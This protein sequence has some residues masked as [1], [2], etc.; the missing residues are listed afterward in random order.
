M[1][2]LEHIGIAVDD[3]ET[4]RSRFAELLGTRPYKTETVAD[5]GVRTHF[6][7]A[8][9]AK[10]ELLE[11]TSADSPVARFLDTHGE[12]IHHIAVEVDD[13]E[14]TMERLRDAGF[15]LLSDAPQ[16]GADDKRICFVHPKATHGV[17][18]EFCDTPRTADWAPTAVPHRDGSLAVYERG[19]RDRPTVL[20]LHGAAGTVR[21]DL[22]P[23]MRRLEPQFHVVAV[24]LSGHGAS[25]LPPDAT[26]A[27]D[28]FVADAQA[29]LDATEVASASVFGF[30]MGASV[31]LRLAQVHP[32]RVERLAL[33][34]P[35][36]DWTDALAET[37]QA[38][39]DLE[40]FQERAPTQARALTTRHEAPKRLLTAL[41]A[42]VATLPDAS[43]GVLKTLSELT[44]PT[45]V[46]ALD[47]DPL[48]PLPDTHT[49]SQVLPNARF[50]VIPGSRHALPAVSLDVLVPLLQQHFSAA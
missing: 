43:E 24:D 22:A 48:F 8:G 6:I 34:S 42:F 45:L 18:V 4:V 31:G 1:A 50:A 9:T 44:T 37:L 49:L 41:R 40:T 3:V 23:L 36:I 30:S 25:S 11:S 27:M 28:R 39:L 17:L 16:A 32:E 13:V 38:R 20:C 29:A 5:Q 7:D 47:D 14:S 12:G 35:R 33:L 46:A 15:P 21:H 2:S 19:R 26:L 10:L